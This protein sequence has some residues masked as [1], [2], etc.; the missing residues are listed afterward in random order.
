MKL[1]ELRR[2]RIQHAAE[3]AITGKQ[4]LR[5]RLGVFDVNAEEQQ[6]LEQLVVGERLRAGL[7]QAR[8]QAIAVTGVLRLLAQLRKGRQLRLKRRRRIGEAARE[9][10][11]GCRQGRR[12]I[13]DGLERG[14]DPGLPAATP[15]ATVPPDK[16]LIGV[17]IAL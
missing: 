14:E 3:A 7:Q 15:T 9:G 2:L 4:L 12:Q 5:E 16:L 17:R 11:P 1:R 6:E 13:A 8:S 10:R